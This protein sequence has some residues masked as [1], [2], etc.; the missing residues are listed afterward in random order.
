[1][2][3]LAGLRVVELAHC[4]VQFAGR[5]L[6]DLGADVLVVEPPGGHESRRYEPFADDRPGD[7]TSLWWWHHNVSKRSTV[8]DVGD[9]AGRARLAELVAEADVLLEGEAPG[10]VAT[11]LGGLPERLV[12][13]AV[14]PYGQDGD[15]PPVV[16]LT[17]LAAGGPVWSCGY[18]DHEVPP[19]RG[20]G[21]Q[22]YQ[23]GCHYAVMAL[24]TALLARDVTGRGQ[25]IDVNM[26]AAANV[27]TEFA[28][29]TWLA[30]RQTVQRQTGRHAMWHPTEPT[31]VQ[32]ADGRWLNTGVPPRTG[33]EFVA[34]GTWI[35]ELGLAD[36]F[37]D[38]AV[39]QLGYDIEYIAVLNL[40]DNPLHA[41]VFGAG[42]AAIEYLARSLPSH[43][44][45]V[46]LQRRGMACG[47]IYAPEEMLVDEHVVAR[48]FPTALRHDDGRTVTYSGSPLRFDGTPCGP[49]RQAPRLGEHDDEVRRDG[50][51]AAPIGRVTQELT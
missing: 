26:H 9:P 25:F 16:D 50:A 24:L 34:L 44:L 40:A 27:T 17:V 4:H 37:D 12:H 23:T 14:T 45:F 51:W 6:A 47:V 21:N 30:A 8:V 33:G 7:E 43:E 15:Y 13:V 3:P 18:D 31:Q 46:G 22:G 38:L 48:G 5:L 2:G 42:R 20:G 10:R 19:V 29:Y 1:M 28:S 36:G 32:C 49:W 35:E 11:L 41:E 39:L